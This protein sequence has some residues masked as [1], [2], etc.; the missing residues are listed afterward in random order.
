MALESGVLRSTLGV[1]A[2]LSLSFLTCKVG[3]AA[4]IPSLGSSG[5][6]ELTIN[7]G[8]CLVHSRFSVYASCCYYFQDREMKD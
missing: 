1:A 2:S 3:I 6:N 4:P 8:Q 5:L 7:T